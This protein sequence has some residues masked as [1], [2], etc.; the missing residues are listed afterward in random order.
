MPE[1]ARPL[2]RHRSPGRGAAGLLAIGR[3]LVKVAPAVAFCLLAIISWEVMARSLASPL[4]P[5]VG[6]IAGACE[7]IVLSGEAF[8]QIGITLWRIALGFVLAFVLSLLVGISSARY[9][10]VR[11]FFEP[12][13]LLGLTVPGLVWALLCVIWFGVSL[14]TPVVSIALGITPALV[15]SVVQG[16]RGVDPDIIEMAHV[17]Q[18]PRRTRLMKIWLPAL[19]PSLLNGGRVAF[20]LAWKVIV[21]VE[22]FGLSDGV[23]YQINSQFSMQNVE[24]VIAWTLVF[25]LGMLLLEY[26]V[27]QVLDR[28]LTRWQRRASV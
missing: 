17:Y 14:A 26:A 24:G 3:W 21:L 15:L 18:L 13:I 25:W 9:D 23:G 11:V 5:G 4:V 10:P 27:F 28:R 19:V 1:L 20:S 2:I 7:S 22:I 8:T 16:I 6:K 12:A